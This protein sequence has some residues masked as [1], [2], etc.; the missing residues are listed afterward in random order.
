[1]FLENILNEKEDAVNNYNFLKHVCGDT[2]RNTAPP[3]HQKSRYFNIKCY[4]KIHFF[5][6][7]LFLCLYNNN[8]L[9]QL[10]IRKCMMH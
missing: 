10:M 2:N 1:M 7:S 8:I 9:S 5:C 4:Q 6:L 3:I